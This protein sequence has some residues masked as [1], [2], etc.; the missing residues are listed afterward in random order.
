MN[1]KSDLRHINWV[2]LFHCEIQKKIFSLRKDKSKGGVLLQWV[3]CILICY[4]HL[5]L[6]YYGSLN[7]CEGSLLK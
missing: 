3:Q 4:F 1:A 2:L 5:Q 6:S 7:N